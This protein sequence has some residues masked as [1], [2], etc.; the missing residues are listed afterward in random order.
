M[1][2]AAATPLRVGITGASGLIGAALTRELT[3]RGDR[4]VKLVRRAP[5]SSDEARWSPEAGIEPAEGSSGLDAVVHL[6]GENI[7]ASRWT[8]ERKRLLRDSRVGATRALA[9]SLARLGPQVPTLVT[10]SATGIYG[11]R[12]DELLTEASAPGSG[13]LAEL[14]CEWEAA[15]NPAR[16]AGT[17]VATVR[18]GLV[19]SPGGGLLERLLLP[20]RMGVGGPV[21]DPRAWWSW[22]T[23]EDAVG[24]IL[25]ALTHPDLKGPCNAVAPGAVTNGAFATAL[26]RAVHR[27]ALLPVPA[28]ALRLLFG[29]MADEMILASQHVLPARALETG[30]VFRQP[31]LS[32]ALEA[33][34]APGAAR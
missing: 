18:F 6:A 29:E 13:F 23:L 31:E 3:R 26:G 25:H 1:T 8:P 2:G 17:R 24:V 14:A 12:G 21:G 4:V 7:A 19:L 10:A 9:E 27:P 28:F 32:G 16:D 22:V 5:A 30:Y 15:A 34:L 20:F 33:V 11:S